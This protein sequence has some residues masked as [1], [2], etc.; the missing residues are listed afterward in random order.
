MN[1][2]YAAAVLTL[3]VPNVIHN[4]KLRLV[5]CD[6]NVSHILRGLILLGDEFIP[7]E[8]VHTNFLGW[9]K[10]VTVPFIQLPNH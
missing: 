2:K 9:Q 6:L 1:I 10:D 4:R 8:C 5:K 7:C 3:K